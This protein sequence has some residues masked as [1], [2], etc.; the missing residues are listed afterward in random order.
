[1]TNVAVRVPTNPLDSLLETRL[2]VDIR[3]QLAIAEAAHG[4]NALRHPAFEQGPHLGDESALDL[5]AHPFVH[6]TIE[7]VAGHR[8]AELE[9][10]ERRRTFALLGRHGDAGFLVD[11]QSANDAT[12]VAPGSLSCHGI[13]LT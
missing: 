2:S 11:L 1:M 13:D 5:A 9:R 12:K 6:S 7:S 4:R 3:Q 8:E 10:L